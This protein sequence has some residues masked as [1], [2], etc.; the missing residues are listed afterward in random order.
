M[1]NP[2]KTVA[3]VAEDSE[4]QRSHFR[5]VTERVDD[6]IAGLKALD[7]LMAGNQDRAISDLSSL[8]TPFVDQLAT[9]NAELMEFFYRSDVVFAYPAKTEPKNTKSAG[10]HH[11][12]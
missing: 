11:D 3:V 9:L 5:D 8:M 2:S 7:T 12:A 4:E 10:D 6:A 1:T